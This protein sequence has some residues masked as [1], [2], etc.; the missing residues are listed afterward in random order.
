MFDGQMKPTT[1]IPEHLESS[2]SETDGA[3]Y[4]SL[5]NNHSSGPA[6]T[7]GVSASGMPEMTMFLDIFGQSRS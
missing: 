2:L 7:A 5:Q 4:K 6:G 3:Y 1:D